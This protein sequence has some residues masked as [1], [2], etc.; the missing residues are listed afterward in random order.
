MFLCKFHI[1][2]FHSYVG[3]KHCSMFNAEIRLFVFVFDNDEDG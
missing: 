3:Y 1:F 2:M